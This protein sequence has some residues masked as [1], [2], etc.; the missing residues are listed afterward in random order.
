MDL[1]CSGVLERVNIRVKNNEI[2]SVFKEFGSH[3][4]NQNFNRKI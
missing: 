3:N 1:S 2:K 4:A